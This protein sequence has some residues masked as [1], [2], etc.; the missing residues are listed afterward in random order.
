MY[1]KGTVVFYVLVNDE[2]VCFFKNIC[3][4]TVLVFGDFQLLSRF[5][6]HYDYKRR[7]FNNNVK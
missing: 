4:R 1:S 6:C 7:T 3:M 5:F 2:M